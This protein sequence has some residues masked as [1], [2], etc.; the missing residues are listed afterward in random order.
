MIKTYA[1]D[2]QKK[3]PRKTLPSSTNDT[4]SDRPKMIHHIFMQNSNFLVK[5]ASETAQL[6]SSVLRGLR[7]TKAQISLRIRTV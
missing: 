6:M 3:R 5:R 1:V 7:T 4:G 2:G